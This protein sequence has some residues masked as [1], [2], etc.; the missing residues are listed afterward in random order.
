VL[1]GGVPH[2]S[3]LGPILFLIYPANFT[4][5][6][7]GSGLRPH[8]YT[9]DTQ[10][11]EFCRPDDTQALIDRTSACIRD[12]ATW[13]KTAVLWCA[14]PRQQHSIPDASMRVCA[15]DVK[16]A[17]SVCDLGVYIDSDM[18]MT[19]HVSR[20]VSS[21]FAALRH[22]RSISRSVSQPVLL[23]LVSGH[24]V[25]SVTTRIRQRH[26]QRHHKASDGSSAVRAQCASE[27]GVQQS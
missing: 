7:E 27:T 4:R 15:D 6:I 8:I 3:V 18:S 13:M 5:L 17:K 10:I 2:G 21:C 19:T 12:V 23:S 14:A 1:S 11:Y 22:I 16:P 25:S 26:T 9:D 20:T 24:L